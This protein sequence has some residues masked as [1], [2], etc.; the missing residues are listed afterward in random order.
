MCIWVCI[1][2]DRSQPVRPAA[3]HRRNPAE[4]DDDTVRAASGHGPDGR[5]SAHPLYSRRMPPATSIPRSP[6]F[7][8]RRP[9]LPPAPLVGSAAR[10]RRSRRLRR[11]AALL[12]AVLAAAAVAP[13]AVA[14]AGDGDARPNIVWIVVDD[15]SPDFSCSGGTAVRT[16]HVDRLAAD[17]T[18][19]SRAFVTAPVCSPSRSALITGMYQTTI[20]AH[21]HRS[22]RGALAIELP[23][24]VRTVPAILKEAGYHTCIGDGLDADGDDPRGRPAGRPRGL[25]KT[26]YNFAWDARIYDGE[27]WAAR[28]PGQPFFMQVMLP[29]GKIRDGRNGVEKARADAIREFGSACDPAGVQLPSYLPRDPVLLADRAAYLDA[30]RLTDAHVGK[31]IARLEREGVLDETLVV[32]LTDH[33][34]SHVRA[35]QFLYDEGTHV[36]LIVRGPGIPRAAVRDDLV[37]HID[38]A[39]VTLAA[40]G[41]PLPA[42]MQARDLFAPD[43]RP[44]SAVFAARDRCDETVEKI[45]SARTADYLYIRNG[46]PGRPLLQPNAYKDAKPTLVRLRE[47]HVEGRLDPLAER[48][49]FAPTRPAEELYRWPDDPWQLHD[50]AAA[51]AH[52]AALAECRGLLDR[53]LAE[54]GDPG[55]EDPARY[56]A[57]MAAYVGGGNPEVERNIATMKRWAA[58]GR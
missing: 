42:A 37:E 56:D 29:G 36:P 19:F 34:I 20:G 53:W 45:R 55:P 1:A 52:A 6:D 28:G 4:D 8:A 35:K 25:G 24:G 46:H 10:P 58:E 43:H 47:L 48:L 49:L 12:A 22:G 54:A 39:A 15:M 41:V 33:G 13:A 51:P 26:D 31:V 23:A 40:A 2:S 57:D 7:A 30:V 5:G 11:W 18:R 44:R 17:G 16:P 50:L 3:G 21:H 9:V 14:A 27:D 38:V 32:F